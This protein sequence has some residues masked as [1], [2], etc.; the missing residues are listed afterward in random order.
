MDKKQE[1]LEPHTLIV[2]RWK[3]MTRV[4]G[5]TPKFT[6]AVVVSGYRVAQVH[7]DVCLGLL[8]RMLLYSPGHFGWGCTGFCNQVPSALRV[9]MPKRF[10]SCPSPCHVT[11]L[12]W[13]PILL[14]IPC[15]ISPAPLHVTI[16]MLPL[17]MPPCPSI[18]LGMPCAI[19]RAPWES[20]LP[21]RP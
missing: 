11:M 8:A 19:S 20:S 6:N 12:P 16:C 18:V 7:C 14:G 21:L 17:S 5:P 13:P 1:G 9:L 4:G 3:G 2:R 10:A 15:A